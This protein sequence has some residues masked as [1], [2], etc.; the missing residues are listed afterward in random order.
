M[1]RPKSGVKSR[2]AAKRPKC[3]EKSRSAAKKAEVKRFGGSAGKT[4]GRSQAAEVRFR[5]KFGIGRSPVS[6]EVQRTQ[7]YIVG[8]ATS[9]IR[10]L[11]S[12]KKNIV[13]K[14]IEV[15]LLKIII[16]TLFP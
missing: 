10:K 4:A 7:I 8:F 2:S 9:G 14:N 1:V 5:P 11:S 6:A 15:Y 12:L 16:S 3:G 13:E